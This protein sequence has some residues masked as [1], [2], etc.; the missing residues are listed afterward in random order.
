MKIDRNDLRDLLRDA[1]ADSSNQRPDADWVAR[2]AAGKLTDSD[3]TALPELLSRHPGLA[4]EIA[5]AVDLHQALQPASAAIPRWVALA[6]VLV[7]AVALAWWMRLPPQPN[8]EQLRSPAAT[9]L[10]R[11]GAVLTEAPADF[12]WRPRSISNRYRVVIF[13]N[14]GN[15]VWESEWVTG[16]RLHAV[17]LKLPPGEYLWRAE[18][19]DDSDSAL[20]PVRRFRIR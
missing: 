18:A 1:A 19:D 20:A 15:S 7:L 3:K 9:V 8:D 2:A 16:T 12:Q 4:E 14:A 11:P 10:P 17:S 5:A 13:D 6:A